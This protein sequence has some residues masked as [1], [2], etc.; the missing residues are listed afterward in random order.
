VLLEDAQDF[1][2]DA[3]G[4]LR[5]GQVV[6]DFSG[7]LDPILPLLQAA[8]K[9]GAMYPSLIIKVRHTNLCK[10]VGKARSAMQ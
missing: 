2:V 3:D 8:Y 1:G 5:T 4:P 7:K 10:V 6:E 9:R